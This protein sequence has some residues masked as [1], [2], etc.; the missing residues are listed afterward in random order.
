MGCSYDILGARIRPEHK[1][2]FIKMFNK[3]LK[4]DLY[5][6]WCVAD[7]DCFS[8][9]E[10]AGDN[11]LV[12]SLDQ[13]PIFTRME[14]GYQWFDFICKYLNEVKDEGFTADYQCTF[15]NCGAMVVTE[16]AYRNGKLKV[17]TKYAE[18]GSL[19]E[20]PECGYDDEDDLSLHAWSEEKGLVCPECGA[21]LELDDASETIEEVD[22]TEYCAEAYKDEP[23]PDWDAVEDESD[24]EDDDFDEDDD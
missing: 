8:E 5:D 7:D 14:N 9:D 21:M 19:Y 22:V 17:H 23:C 2:Q 10:M 20:C 1:K 15:N 13:E 4:D 3:I 6:D 11:R 18:E 16:Y 24:D 12:F